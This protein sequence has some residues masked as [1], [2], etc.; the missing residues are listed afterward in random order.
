M[1]QP[2]SFYG[3][4]NNEKQNR[5]SNSNEQTADIK[6]GNTP[7]SQGRGDISTNKSTRYTQYDGDEDATWIFLPSFRLFEFFLKL[8]GSF[9]IAF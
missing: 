8:I 1:K 3:P 5:A 7:H 4:V 2:L 9:D 6:T